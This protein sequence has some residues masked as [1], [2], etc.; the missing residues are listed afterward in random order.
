MI[1]LH[2]ANRLENLIAPLADAIATQQRARPLDRVTIV[3]PSRSIEQ[4][5]KHRVSE[6]I[7]IAANL[8]FPFLRRFLSGVLKAA[9]SQVRIL[10]VEELELVLFESLRAGLRDSAHDFH[11]PRAYIE[12]G[13]GTEA[14]KELRT[15]RLARQLAGLF[16]EYSITRR[17]MLQKWIRDGDVKGEQFSET[18]KWQ[19]HLW[20]S[21]FAANGYLRSEWKGDSECNWILLPGAFEAVSTSSLKAALPSAVHVFGLAY[22]GPAYL[23]IFSQI[24]NL[25]ELNIYAL[26]P[27]LEFWEDVEHLSRIDRESWARHHS[28][29]GGDLDQSTDPFNFNAAGDTPALRL[30]ARPGREYIRMLNELTEC[31]FD[32]HFI[33]QNPSGPSSLLGNLQED[34]LN[35]EPERV[36]SESN[37]PEDDA[38][39]LEQ[40]WGR[41]R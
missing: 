39:I 6:E 19:K 10:D 5:L 35:R 38:S 40:C 8:D 3:V 16:R 7:G 17:S 23:R 11:A 1:R 36:P 2:Y 26:N 20:M 4:F 30:W 9:D 21:T 24:G 29:V 37:V 32:A 13:E 33:H 28:K 14:E 15:L 41:I 22:A 27:C 25:T 34:I 18:E 31:D 12:M